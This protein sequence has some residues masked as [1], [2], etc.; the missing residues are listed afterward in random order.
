MKVRVLPTGAGRRV[1]LEFHNDG[2]D[3]EYLVRSRVFLASPDGNFFD[4]DQPVRY[5][6]VQVK[7]LP[8]APEDLVSCEPGAV[9]E[10][11]IDLDDLYDF[12]STNGDVRVRYLT[13]H[14]LSDRDGVTMVASDWVRLG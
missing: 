11:T 3:T 2:P 10:T 8:Y 1:R 4:F 14:P 5:L 13:S 7:R 9:L 12:A 6:G